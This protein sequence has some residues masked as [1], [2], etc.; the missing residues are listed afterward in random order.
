MLSL[1][2]LI[3]L[4]FIFFTGSI[5]LSPTTYSETSAHTTQSSSIQSSPP[6]YFLWQESLQSLIDDAEGIEL[7]E[8]F[9]KEMDLL[10][11]LKFL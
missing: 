5:D 7:F 10:Y 6:S 9:L 8:E 4:F 2:L 3:N 1:K 11:L